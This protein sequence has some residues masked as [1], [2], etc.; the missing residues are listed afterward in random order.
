MKYF[1][2]VLLGI[3]ILGAI[4]LFGSKEEAMKQEVQEEVFEEKPFAIINDIE[5]ELEIVR[6]DEEK[7]RGLSGRESLAANAG[8]LFLYDQQTTPSFWM[9]EMNFP[10]DIIWI[11]GDKRIVDITENIAPETFP[12]LF[13]PRASVQY[14]LEVNATWAK[15]HNVAIGDEVVLNGIF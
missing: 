1:V 6:T 11:G 15:N 2:L 14:V 3:V 9:K 4:L 5:I 12:Q 10:I 7:A 13:R 8:M